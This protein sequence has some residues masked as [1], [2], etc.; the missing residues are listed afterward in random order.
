[1]GTTPRPRP[2]DF[3]EVALSMPR[4]RILAHYG[5]GT[6]P[7]QRWLR[8]MPDD[9][10][11][12]RKA[13]FQPQAVQ[14]GKN[15]QAIGTEAYVTKRL[16]AMP[17]D[18]VEAACAMTRVDLARHYNTSTGTVHRL[19]AKLSDDDRAMIEE[20][21][22]ER[23]AEASARNAGKAAEARASKCLA[24]R[25]AELTAPVNRQMRPAQRSNASGRFNKPVDIAPIPGGHAAQ[26]A[27]HLRRYY[28]PVY[29]G[30]VLNKAL[31][32]R[33]V[34]GKQSLDEAAMI[35]L[36]RS[37]GWNPDAWRVAA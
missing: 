2:A 15:I 25:R 12:A 11:A 14:R 4:D 37:K 9:W 3:A 34:V 27:Q 19:M 20:A 21:G 13:I 16:L 29:R 18:F 35:A 8:E 6:A 32:G 5:C 33:Y 26:A 10:K 28:V 36:A 7:A 1:M 24:V 23:K 17:A 22:R 30:D 31:K